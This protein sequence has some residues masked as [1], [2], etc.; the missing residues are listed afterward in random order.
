MKAVDVVLQVAQMLGKE[1]LSEFLRSGVSADLSQ[2]KKDRQTIIDCLNNVI[3]EL[4][5]TTCKLKC[6][7]IFEPLNSKIFYKDFSKKILSVSSVLDLHGSVVSYRSFPTHIALYNDK[8]VKI[9]YNYLPNKASLT[10]NVEVGSPLVTETI[11]SYGTIAEYYLVNALYE[12]S[13]IWRQKYE[14]NLSKVLQG[15]KRYIKGRVFA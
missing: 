13:V 11:I 15:K 12:E 14:E 3:Y 8:K 9:V 2:A 1:D 10:Q 5:T 6:E 4:A 7:E